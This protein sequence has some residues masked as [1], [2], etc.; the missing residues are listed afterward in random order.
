MRSIS[1]GQAYLKGMRLFARQV[2][3]AMADGSIDRQDAS[4]LLG[5]G[6]Q[7]V[8]KFVAELVKGD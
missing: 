3:G 5:V 2:V 6:E 8:G 1:A 4:A 7:N